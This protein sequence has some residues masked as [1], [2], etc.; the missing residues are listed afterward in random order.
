MTVDLAPYYLYAAFVESH[1]YAIYVDERLTGTREYFNSLDH[2]VDQRSTP[3]DALVFPS[4]PKRLSN[5][6]QLRPAPTDAQKF[7]LS[8][9]TG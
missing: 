6:K 7:D 4:L 9:D 3:T 1:S 5:R 8:D 2:R